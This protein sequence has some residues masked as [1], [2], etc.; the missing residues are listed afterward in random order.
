MTN[1]IKQL[2]EAKYDIG[3]KSLPRILHHFTKGIYTNDRQLYY[4]KKGFSY[5]FPKHELQPDALRE[6]QR[7]GVCEDDMHQG[8]P[9]PNVWI[10]F[11]D[12]NVLNVELDFFIQHIQIYAL[13]KVI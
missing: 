4:P 1:L 2:E 7:I 3:E 10:N 12:G 9:F 6:I 5:L 11:I 8:R 13:R